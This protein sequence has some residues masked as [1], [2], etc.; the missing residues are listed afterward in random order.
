MVAAT[1]P[2]DQGLDTATLSGKNAS[3]DFKLI[4]PSGSSAT[5][6]N[7]HRCSSGIA[8]TPI[9]VFPALVYD[10]QYGHG[11][12]VSAISAAFSG[13][14]V[15]PNSIPTIEAFSSLAITHT[16]KNQTAVLQIQYHCKF[17]SRNERPATHDGELT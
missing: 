14:L 13:V 16:S 9:M 4:V 11:R 6:S 5:D 2:R 17:L 7:H 10:A 12:N 15:F 8:N 3:A 1:S